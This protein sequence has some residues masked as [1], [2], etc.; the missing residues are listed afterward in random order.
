MCTFPSTC[1]YLNKHYLPIRRI[2]RG[3]N[4][5]IRIPSGRVV[6]LS[7]N[8]P[9]VKPRFS[10]S[11]WSTQL[12]HSSTSPSEEELPR[13][14]MTESFT[15]GLIVEGRVRE[16]AAAWFGADLLNLVQKIWCFLISMQICKSPSL[17][18]SPLCTRCY[19]LYCNPPATQVLMQCAH[20]NQIHEW[21]R[22]LYMWLLHVV[23]FHFVKSWKDTEMRIKFW[24]YQMMGGHCEREVQ[25]CWFYLSTGGSRSLPSSAWWA[26]SPSQ[27]TQPSTAGSQWPLSPP[28]T[29]ASCRP[30]GERAPWL[31]LYDE[32]GDGGTD[33]ND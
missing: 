16:L 29:T 30:G 1:D 19:P 9:I 28:S 27:A 25:S 6:A 10:I 5:S 18:P 12:S 21:A 23:R 14:T 33:D 22:N 11:S 8:E 7:K 17:Y 26:G 2:G 24:R 15:V 4:L 32:G 13:V 3:P 20:L 31:L